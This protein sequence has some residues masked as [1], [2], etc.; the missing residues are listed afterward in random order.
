MCL[1]HRKPRLL[2]HASYQTTTLHRR[3]YCCRC[4]YTPYSIVLRAQPNPTPPQQA[5]DSHSLSRFS[6]SSQFHPPQN[7]RFCKLYHLRSRLVPN[8]PSRSWRCTI[9]PHHTNSHCEWGGYPRFQHQHLQDRCIH[10]TR[11]R[12]ARS[13]TH[14]KSLRISQSGMSRLFAPPRRNF[15]AASHL[16]R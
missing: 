1:H 14:P 11:P 10:S 8:L 4:K 9:S 13:S 12:R 3:D 15:A 16:G 5:S 6:I 7:L 2:T